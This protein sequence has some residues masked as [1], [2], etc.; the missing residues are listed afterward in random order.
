MLQF[1]RAELNGKMV[2]FADKLVSRVFG[3]ASLL[4]VP[5]KGIID[6]TARVSA[7]MR[8]WQFSRGQKRSFGGWSGQL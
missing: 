4:L 8:N 5:H 3:G 6:R 7:A 2:G 1:R